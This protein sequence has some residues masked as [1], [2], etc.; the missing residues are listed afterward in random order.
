LKSFSVPLRSTPKDFNFHYPISAGNF[1]LWVI[2][3]D[4]AEK[5]KKKFE[6]GIDNIK[7]M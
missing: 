2:S 1:F 6:K 3:I 7:I 5:I 4:N